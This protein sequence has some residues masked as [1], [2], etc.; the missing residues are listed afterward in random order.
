[1]FL[2]VF[3]LYNKAG[4]NGY[5]GKMV[6]NSTLPFVN[7]IIHKV[8]HALIRRGVGLAMHTQESHSCTWFTISLATTGSLTV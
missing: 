3:I 6:F 5:H 1:M 8:D 7:N 2:L 4:N